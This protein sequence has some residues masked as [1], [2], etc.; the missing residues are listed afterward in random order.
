MEQIRREIKTIYN[1]MLKTMK[2]VILKNIP[3]CTKKINNK[4][5]KTKGHK[6][7]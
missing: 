6:T 3:N 5:E 1:S 7:K 2:Q 4:L